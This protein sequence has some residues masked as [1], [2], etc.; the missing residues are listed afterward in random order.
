VLS[1]SASYLCIDYMIA[2]IIQ[3]RTSSTRLPN[4]VF[5]DIEGSP[6]ISHVVDRVSRSRLIEKIIIATTKN[7][8][9]DTL[10]EY[11]I[12][13]NIAVFRGDE[14]DVLLR[15]F[16]AAKQY[17]V[18][19][20]ARIT[21]DDPFK[22][23]QVIDLVIRSFLDYRVDFAYNNHPPTFPEGLDVE[24]FSYEALAQAVRDSFNAFEREHV[25]QYFYRNPNRFKQINVSNFENLSDLRWTIDSQEDLDMAREVY[26]KLYQNGEIFYMRDILKL[27]KRYPHIANINKDV[28]RSALYNK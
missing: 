28:K 13:N 24:V 14:N 16:G 26:S 21:A 25:T 22:D 2:A 20:I 18:T 5:A 23:P 9:D 17:D 27:L 12:N 6:L 19:T 10:E 15:F 11:A 1:P 3:A 4:K 7:S 8:H